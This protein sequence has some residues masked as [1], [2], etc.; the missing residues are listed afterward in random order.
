MKYI[1]LWTSE[2]GLNEWREV[3]AIELLA[4]IGLANTVKA[5]RVEI[6]FKPPTGTMFEYLKAKREE[7]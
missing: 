1:V 2:G 7:A 5:T 3:D 6:F 4:T